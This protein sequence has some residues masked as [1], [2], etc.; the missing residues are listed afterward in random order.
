MCVCVQGR[1]KFITRCV[2]QWLEVPPRCLSCAEVFFLPALEDDVI[3][4]VELYVFQCERE[5]SRS[6]YDC[7]GRGVLRPVAR[8]LE[9]IFGLVPRDDATEMSADGVESKVL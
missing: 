9:L 8:A 5:G 7:A 3:L 2:V 6:T 1:Q 4:F